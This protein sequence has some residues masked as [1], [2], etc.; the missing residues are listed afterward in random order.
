MSSRSAVLAEIE[1]LQNRKLWHQVTL[2]LYAYVQD[3]EVMKSE[4]LMKL[5]TD[6][7]QP[8]EN[9]MN[10]FTFIK[11]ISYVIKQISDPKEIITFLETQEPK[12]KNDKEALI[13]CKILQG[14]IHLEKLK[15][16]EEATKLIN[17]IETLLADI[18]EIGVIHNQ[19]YFLASQLYRIQSKHTEFYRTCLKYLGSMDI[20]SIAPKEQMQ[21]AFLLSLAALLSDDIYNL[22]ELLQHPILDSMKNTPNEWLIDLLHTF[23]TG[24]IRKFDEMQPKW[25][26]IG[27]IAVQKDKLRRKISLLCLMEMT[28]KRQS[29]DRKLTFQD[30]AKETKLPLDEVEL[31]VMKAL[32][33]GLVKGS[34]DQVAQE[35][36]LNWVQP[37]VIDKSQISSMVKHLDLWLG[38][39]NSTRGIIEEKGI[40]FLKIH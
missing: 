27:D 19:Y 8:I 25:A 36:H 39:V 2:K 33:L 26:S 10:P 13:C 23:N 20:S 38:D 9:K 16:Q 29:K 5:Y 12:V 40:D 35:V 30:I 21:H 14:E 4:D 3:P 37:R 34:I 18:E 24:D 28:F 32:A 17:E 11:I 31:L 15:N 22:G 7:I 6:F 1:Q